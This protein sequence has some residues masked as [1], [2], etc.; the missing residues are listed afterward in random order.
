MF[1]TSTISGVVIY[2]VPGRKLSVYNFLDAGHRG[3]VHKLAPGDRRYH[4]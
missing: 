1:A 3:P 4:T 2:E